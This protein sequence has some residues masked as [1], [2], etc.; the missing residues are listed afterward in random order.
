MSSV[1]C[2][3][4]RWLFIHMKTAVGWSP[5]QIFNVPT[6]SLRHNPME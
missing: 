3:A 1:F 2:G 4:L 5:D 6:H